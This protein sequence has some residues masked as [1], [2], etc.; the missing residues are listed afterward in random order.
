MYTVLWWFDALVGAVIVGFFLI[1]LTDGS[2][3]SFNMALWAS[4]L[5]A[6]GVILFGSRALFAAGNRK[7]ALAV[8]WLMALPGLAACVFFL[9]ILIAQ[10]RWN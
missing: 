4:L 6:V 8:L 7:S 5:V 3:S 1:G 9:A 10:P 2:V